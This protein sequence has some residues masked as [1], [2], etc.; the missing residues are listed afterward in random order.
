MGHLGRREVVLL[1]I[2]ETVQCMGQVWQG[3]R[4]AGGKEWRGGRCLLMQG[5]KM[6]RIGENHQVVGHLPLQDLHLLRDILQSQTTFQ[7]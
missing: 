4:R 1:D 3:V 2:A 6:L 7:Y 5:E